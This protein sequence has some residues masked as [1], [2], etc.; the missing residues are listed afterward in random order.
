MA[1]S[2]CVVFV[3]SGGYIEGTASAAKSAGAL[4]I[5]SPSSAPLRALFKTHNAW[6]LNDKRE[7]PFKSLWF[8]RTLAGNI[9]AG[10]KLLFVFYESFHLSY[11]A[12]YLDSLKKRYPEARM[13]FMFTNPSSEYNLKKVSAV[14]SQYDLIVTFVKEDALRYGFHYYQFYPFEVQGADVERC[15]K[16]SSDLVFI[17]ANKGRLAKLLEIFDFFS[18]QGLKCDFVIDGVSP[19]EQRYGDRIQYNKR[20]S[21]EESLERISQSRCVLDLLPEGSS[22]CSIRAIE[23]FALKKKLLATNV[24]LQS[25]EY[26]DCRTMRCLKDLGEEDC[27]FIRAPIGSAIFPNLSLWSFQRFQECIERRLNW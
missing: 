10:D 24:G 11:S 12:K 17:G 22:Y 6:R 23:A 2:R 15:S 5:Q 7:L 8:R 4:L 14:R 25:T 16:L 18:R 1:E 19:E 9:D 20:I 3:N 21:Y 13:V 26:Y 27:E